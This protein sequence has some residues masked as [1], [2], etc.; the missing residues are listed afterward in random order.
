MKLQTKS[1]VRYIFQ[2]NV[3]KDQQL[4]YNYSKTKNQKSK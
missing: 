1:L 4:N 2:D 3:Y